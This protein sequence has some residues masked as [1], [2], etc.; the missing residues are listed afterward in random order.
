MGSRNALPT[1]F[2]AVIAFLEK[3]TFPVEEVVTEVVPLAD[4][5]RALAAWSE[6][7]GSVCKI[8]VE[9]A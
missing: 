5:G 9:I 1:D 2:K 4:A 7:P 3:G 8:H 6:S